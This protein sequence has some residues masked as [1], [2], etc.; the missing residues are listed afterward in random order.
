MDVTHIGQRIKS[1]I[2]IG[3]LHLDYF[4]LPR[5]LYQHIHKHALRTAT[6]MTFS[7]LISI[8]WIREGRNPR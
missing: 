4:G 2:V 7:L 3:N 8:H 6:R 5:H 1:V